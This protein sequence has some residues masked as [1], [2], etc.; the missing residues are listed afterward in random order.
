MELSYTFPIAETADNLIWFSVGNQ[1]VIPP[2]AA[3]VP[4]QAGRVVGRALGNPGGV[5]LI[6]IKPCLA[7]PGVQE[8]ED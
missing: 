2:A 3:T 8:G 5:M 1:V 4:V 7:E 6:T